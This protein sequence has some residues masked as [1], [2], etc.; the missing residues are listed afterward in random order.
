MFLELSFSIVPAHDQRNAARVPQVWERSN[1]TA[2]VEETC[3][4]TWPC[5]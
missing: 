5:A 4:R 3:I 1:G 2:P